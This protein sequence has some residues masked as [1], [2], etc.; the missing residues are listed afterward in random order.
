MQVSSQLSDVSK[1]KKPL[2]P[3]IFFSQEFRE[4]IRQ[5]F[6]SLNSLQIMKA[7]SFKWQ[8]LSKEQKDPFERAST[9]D[10]Q[11]YER[12]SADFK[13]GSFQGRG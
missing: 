10:K 8:S 6:S 4:I 3:Y 1:P 13:K 5:R 11:R 2:S 7:V 12:E 9:E